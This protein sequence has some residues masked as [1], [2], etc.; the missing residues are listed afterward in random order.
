MSYEPKPEPSSVAVV[1]DR[2]R[3]LI[4]DD[5]EDQTRVLSHRLE[6]QGFKSE[7]CF[8]GSRV[9]DSVRSERPHLIIMDVRLP[10]A[11]GLDICET[12]SDDPEA[13]EIPIIVV[14]GTD[15]PNAVRKARAA[16]G[17]Y[18]VRKPYDPNALLLLIKH[19]LDEIG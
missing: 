7:C 6:S 13:H 14:S 11:N 3:V 19:S 4:V 5:D 8:R 16:G 1:D 12:L 15:L 10:D 18:Y 2:P 9:M 17:R